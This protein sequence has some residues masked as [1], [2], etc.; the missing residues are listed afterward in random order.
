MIRVLSILATGATV[1]T[2]TAVAALAV[3][4]QSAWAGTSKRPAL[5]RMASHTATQS[6]DLND[7]EGIDFGVKDGTSNTVVFAERSAGSTI[8]IGTSE[9]ARNGTGRP[10]LRRAK[11]TQVTGSNGII[12]VLIGL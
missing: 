5:P 11:L 8:D 10:D 7:V 9:A 4:A 1:A 6:R 3:S 12:A 2:V